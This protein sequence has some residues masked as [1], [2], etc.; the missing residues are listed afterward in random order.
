[1]DGGRRRA[2]PLREK[3]LRRR[4]NRG[5]RPFCKLKLNKLRGYNSLRMIAVSSGSAE[6]FVEVS[7]EPAVRGFLHT[8]EN[9]SGHALVLTHGAGAPA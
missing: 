8:P 3:G 5:Q 7:A 9:A 1:M 4:I 6:E 2:P